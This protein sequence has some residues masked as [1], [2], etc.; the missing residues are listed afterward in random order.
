[1][2]QLQTINSTAI[3]E[4]PTA[5]PMDENAAAVYLATLAAGSSRTT[6]RGAL[7]TIAQM[8]TVNPAA[9][10]F[11]FP[12]GRLQ[13]HHVAAIK[14]ELAGKYAYS[15][16][17]KMLSALRGAIRA[18]FALGQMDSDTYMMIK[19]SIKN[20][21]GSRLPAGRA[22]A[23]G[24]LS[25]LLDACGRKDTGTRDAAMIAL[26]YVG[27]LR[28]AE[29]VGLDLADYDQGAATIKIRG[30]GNKERLT[31]IGQAAAFLSDWLDIRGYEPGALF[32]GTGNKN[33]GGRLT[34]QAVYDMI[35]RRARQAG[36]T[37]VSPHD[38]RRTFVSDLLERGADL[39]T[40]KE[41]AGHESVQTTAR[42]D[43][44]GE[45]AKKQAAALLHVPYRRG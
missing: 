16:T 15:T 20:V 30:K 18:A 21:K 31:Y 11:G 22:I 26:L 6:M 10:A 19:E 7:D 17:N 25:A 4:M 13:F 28:R 44:R 36:I 42:Y 24:E 2:S 39:A 41:M 1:M 23:S 34:T 12:W 35:K 32:V 3:V 14:S 27:G 5:R 45:K 9:D 38:F 43:R 40:V 8:V 29:I 33:R 37:A